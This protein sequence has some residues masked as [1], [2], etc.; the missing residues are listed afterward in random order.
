MHSLLIPLP[1]LA[2]P[3]LEC[4]QITDATISAIRI[5]S[6]NNLGKSLLNVSG[7]FTR[8]EVDT[9]HDFANTIL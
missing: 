5:S 8:S 7:V 1:E 2:F 6:T 3:E 9:H 4:P